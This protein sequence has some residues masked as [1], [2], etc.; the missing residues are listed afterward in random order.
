LPS[1]EST[2]MDMTIVDPMPHSEAP[3]SMISCDRGM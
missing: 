2:A 3:T 1:P